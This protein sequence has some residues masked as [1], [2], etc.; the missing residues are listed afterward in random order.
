MGSKTTHPCPSTVRYGQGDHCKE[1][2]EI[3]HADEGTDYAHEGAI[4][5]LRFWLRIARDKTN[6]FP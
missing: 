2:I 6:R 4:Y 5:H 3:I 1:H